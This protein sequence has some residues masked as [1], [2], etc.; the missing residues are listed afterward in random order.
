MEWVRKGKYMKDSEAME[1]SA[2][3]RE[4]EGV[5][6]SRKEGERG[7]GERGSGER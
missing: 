6:D 3:G 4:N 1:L 7:I 5:R 2:S